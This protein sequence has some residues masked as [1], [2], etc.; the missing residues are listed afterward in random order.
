[1]ERGMVVLSVRSKGEQV[2]K[3][4]GHWSRTRRD[5]QDYDNSDL[6]FSHGPSKWRGRWEQRPPNPRCFILG[7]LVW[8][9]TCIIGPGTQA[10]SPI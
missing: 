7:T 1:M 6:E 4:W 10:A 9:E 3:G 5:A 2:Q 8:P